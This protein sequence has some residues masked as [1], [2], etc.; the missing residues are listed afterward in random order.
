MKMLK[1]LFCIPLFLLISCAG[2]ETENSRQ[3]TTGVILSVSSDSYTGA[4]V[5]RPYEADETLQYE[6]TFYSRDSLSEFASFSGSIAESGTA[7]SLPAG[8]YTVT[9]QSAVI[10]VS[11]TENCVLRGCCDFTVNSD[12][13][14]QINVSLKPAAV[15]VVTDQ[16][17]ETVTDVLADKGYLSVNAEMYDEVSEDGG[18][19][20]LVASDVLTGVEQEIELSYSNLTL[21]EEG[22]ELDDGVYAVRIEYQKDGQLVYTYPVPNDDVILIVKGLTTRLSVTCFSSIAPVTYFYVTN[23]DESEYNG[24]SSGNWASLNKMIEL[25]GSKGY[26]FCMPEYDLLTFTEFAVVDCALVSDDADFII[27]QLIG[28]NSGITD[29]GSSWNYKIRFEGSS[30]TI[31]FSCDELA[32]NSGTLSGDYTVLYIKNGEDFN[33]ELDESLS[34]FLVNHNVVNYDE[35]EVTRWY[36]S[37]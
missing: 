4:R 13:A 18:S 8:N 23:D 12:Q 11:D 1:A 34:D 2:F 9:V 29:S 27:S 7:Y 35:E 6:V 20:V 25:Y 16:G 36:V 14:K 22:A 21:T 10:S 24:F 31:Y 37:K 33:M 17:S 5:I 30:K 26:E 15:N 3:E 19:F 28:G 32:E